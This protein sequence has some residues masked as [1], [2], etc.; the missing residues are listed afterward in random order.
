VEEDTMK[1]KV[2]DVMSRAVVAVDESTPFKEIVELLARHRVSAVPVLD[3]AR[4]VT[5]VVSEADLLLKEEHPEAGLD[6]PRFERRRQRLERAKA[7]GAVA[8]ELMTSPAVTIG[9]LATVGEA[10]RLMHTADVKRLPVVDPVTGALVGVVS[11]GDLLRVFTR[12]DAE[13]RR[14][15][16]DQVIL[17][18]FMMDPAQFVVQVSDAVVSL[19]G[20]CERRSLIPL[21][22]RSVHGV[23]GVVRV[24]NRLGYDL[25]DRELPA[26]GPWF[27]PR[28]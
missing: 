14:E 26:P 20:T 17:R 19:Q 22:V 1:T 12:P 27:T 3:A 11:R 7:A 6:A 15:V 5:G 2:Q 21:L 8:R 13:I 25:D 4:H 23:E 10:A 18:E 28:L 24:D 9:L 16:V